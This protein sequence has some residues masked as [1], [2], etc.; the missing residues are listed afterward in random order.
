MC[1]ERKEIC[2]EPEKK[3]YKDW[4]DRVERKDVRI[5]NVGDV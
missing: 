1:Q 5:G 3:G 4:Q 2:L